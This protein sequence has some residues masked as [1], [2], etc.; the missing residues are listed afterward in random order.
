MKKI[1]NLELYNKEEVLE[2]IEKLNKSIKRTRIV[3]TII[4][5]TS[6]CLYFGAI[7]FDI[8][9]LII[10][11]PPFFLMAILFYCLQILITIYQRYF[12]LL[13]RLKFEDEE[14]IE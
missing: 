11:T 6:I 3:T 10:I 14:L 5:I 8:F 7:L 4:L 12:C 13:Y 9:E 1:N 2:T